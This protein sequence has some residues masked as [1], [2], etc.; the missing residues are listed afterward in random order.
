MKNT[1]KIIADTFKDYQFF[2]EGHYY[3]Y[4]G[5]KVGI[6]T[7]SLIH[8]YSKPFEADKIAG[9][10][11]KRDKTTKAKVLNE[12]RLENLHSTVKGT[13]IHEYAQDMWEG[14]TPKFN[15]KDVPKE[16]NLTRLKNDLKIL[17]K[18]AKSHYNDYKDR[19]E[20]LW[21]ELYVGY[22]DVDECGAV[23]VIFWDTID[24][25]IV[26]SDYKSNKEIKREGYKGQMMLD[27]LKHLPDCNFIHYSL[28]L[29]MYEYKFEEMTNLKVG[30]T[31]IIY[32]DIN[33]KEYQVIEPLDLK[34]EAENILENRRWN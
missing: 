31:E 9:F 12:W 13:M 30:R 32:F 5:E 27:I 34:K 3:T 26:V 10:I 17:S 22:P 7:T 4:K 18:Q 11:A 24:K 23:D 33:S 14:K 8:K 15:W 29:S 28:Q 6:S 1:K 16:V 2:D 20:M 19:Y 21:I 25:Y